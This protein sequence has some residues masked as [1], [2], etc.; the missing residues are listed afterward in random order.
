MKKRK[1]SKGSQKPK[2]K[3]RAASAKPARQRRQQPASGRSLKHSAS[4]FIQSLPYGRAIA[5]GAKMAQSALSYVTGSGDYKMQGQTGTI[6]GAPLFANRGASKNGNLR[7]QHREYLQDV[8]ST[9]NF[10]LGVLPINPGMAQTFPFLSAIASNFEEYILHGMMFYFRTLSGTAVGSTSTALGAVV[11]ATQYDA[12][13]AAFANKYEMENYQFASSAAPCYDQIHMVECKRR[14]TPIQALFVRNSAIPS[15]AD[16]RLYDIGTFNFATVGMQA[17]SNNVVGELWCTYDIELL[18]PR[19]PSG[20]GQGQA[21]TD[22]FQLVPGNI[23]SAHPL[24]GLL[25]VGSSTIGGLLSNNNTYSFNPTTTSGQYLAIWSCSG[26]ATTCTAA[27]TITY[28]TNLSG[29][30]MWASDLAGAIFDASNRTLMTTQWIAIIFKFNG[31][32][33]AGQSFFTI[34]NSPTIPASCTSGDLFVTTLNPSLLTMFQQR[35]ASADA[36][37]FEDFKKFLAAT[38]KSQLLVAPETRETKETKHAT[39]PSCVECARIGDAACFK[40]IFEYHA[41]S[42]VD[43]PICE[44]CDI[45]SVTRRPISRTTTSSVMSTPRL[46]TNYPA[47]ARS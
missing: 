28:G 3:R 29:I 16:L 35:V 21:L 30:N 44:E 6:A 43:L 5:A 37:L 19:V 15:G 34:G 32:T 10:N 33:A 23:T 36:G 24:P 22:H 31:G 12:L 42:H 8:T 17:A 18:K 4:S 7:F 46:I 2:T 9:T 47:T 13:S 38:S 11:M 26:S 45:P 25:P 40:C 1:S 27:P 39:T 20:Q 14:E 41:S